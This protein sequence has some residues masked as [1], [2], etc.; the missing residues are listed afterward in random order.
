MASPRSETVP[1]ANL[2]IVSDVV[3]PWCYIGKH[4]LQQGLKRLE[5]VVDL[6]IRW[7]PFE[8]NPGLPVAGMDRAEYCTAK[9]GSLANANKIYNN[10]AAAAREDGLPINVDRINRTPNTR[11]A[12]RLIEFAHISGREDAMVDALFKAYFVDGEDVGDHAVLGRLAVAA[13]LDRDAA[14]AAIKN[15]AADG[16]IERRE[17]QAGEL[18]VHGVPAFLY[19]QRLLFAGAQTPETISLALKRAVRKGL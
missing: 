4:R 5:G 15:T 14:A 13:G 10:I 19:N 6:N 16:A 17:R 8:L 11:A 1:A 12:H 18:G 2:D 3:C 7:R 9:F